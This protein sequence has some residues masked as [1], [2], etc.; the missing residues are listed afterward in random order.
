[1]STKGG[2]RQK[3]TKSCLHSLWMFPQCTF[4]LITK[5]SAKK[6]RLELS[7]THKFPVASQFILNGPLLSKTPIKSRLVN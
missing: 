5:S 3:S 4:F 1:M 6:V 2:G 7:A